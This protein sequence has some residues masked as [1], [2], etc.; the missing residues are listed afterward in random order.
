MPKYECHL[1]SSDDGK[2]E[3][4]LGPMGIYEANSPEQAVEMCRE[5]LPLTLTANNFDNVMIATEIS[6]ATDI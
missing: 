4:N 2:P 6:N 3:I 5:E 1:W